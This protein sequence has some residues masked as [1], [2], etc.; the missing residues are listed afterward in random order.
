MF[1]E[2]A[3]ERGIKMLWVKQ[4]LMDCTTISRRDMREEVNKF[5]YTVMQEEPLDPTLVDFDDS[6]AW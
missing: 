3:R 4:D 5:M 6:L 1:E 2:Q